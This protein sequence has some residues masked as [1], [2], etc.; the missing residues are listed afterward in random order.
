MALDKAIRHGKERRLPYRG[1]AAVSAGCRHGGDCDWCRR[2]RTHRD[3]K[4][5]AAADERMAEVM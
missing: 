2:N 1:A 4:R 3:R 5:R